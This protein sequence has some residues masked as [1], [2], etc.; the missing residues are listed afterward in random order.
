MIALVNLMKSRSIIFNLGILVFNI[1]KVSEKSESE[2]KYLAATF[3]SICIIS[4][5]VSLQFIGTNIIPS[6]AQ[7]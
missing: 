7:A 2:N 4:K 1:F 5:P 6:F 3:L